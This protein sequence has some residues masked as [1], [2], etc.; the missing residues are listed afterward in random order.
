MIL[1]LRIYNK[2]NIP[3]TLFIVKEEVDVNED[4][5]NDNI[6]DRFYLY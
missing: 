5:D 1:L 4:N 2:F 6:F 3:K